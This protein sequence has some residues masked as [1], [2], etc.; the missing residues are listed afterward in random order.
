LLPHSK[1]PVALTICTEV[2]NVAYLLTFYVSTFGA[3]CEVFTEVK[4]HIQVFWFVTLYNISL[5]YC[6]FRGSCYFHVEGE[7][8]GGCAALHGIT[9]QKTSICIYIHSVMAQRVIHLFI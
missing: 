3:R 5:G 2:C 4:I 1:I 8:H 9:T 6:R 7:V